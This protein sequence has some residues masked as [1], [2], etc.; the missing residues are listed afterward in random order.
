MSHKK[1]YIPSITPNEIPSNAMHQMKNEAVE[2]SVLSKGVLSA[3]NV[4]VSQEMLA[5][6]LKNISI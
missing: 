6:K 1:D 3:G 5:L 2:Q 4:Q